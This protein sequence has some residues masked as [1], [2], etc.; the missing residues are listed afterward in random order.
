[1][2]RPPKDPADKKGITLKV[3]VTEDQ[4]RRLKAA[5]DADGLDLS[6]WVRRLALKE[7]TRVNDRVAKKA[8]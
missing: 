8:K 1:M 7:S 2:P 4:Q 3:R 5:A 6:T